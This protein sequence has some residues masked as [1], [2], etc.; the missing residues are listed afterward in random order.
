M[1]VV[2]DTNVLI[3][4][5]LTA[6]GLPQHILT[7]A[8]K[9]HRVILSEYVIREFEEKLDRKLKIPRPLIRQA[10]DFLR[11]RAVVMDVPKESKIEFSDQKDVP[12]LSLVETSRAN[13]FVTGDQ[14]L[15]AIKKLGSTLF[16]SPREAMEVL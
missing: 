6:T 11:K 12:V 10:A 16:L 7:R 4:G 5:F 2:F 3:S 1:T 15:L 14:K 8:F 13:Y 9:R